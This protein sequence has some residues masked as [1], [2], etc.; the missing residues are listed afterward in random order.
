I[1]KK[2]EIH[3]VGKSLTAKA[4][5]SAGI[6][7]GVDI[8]TKNILLASAAMTMAILLIMIFYDIRISRKLG[9]KRGRL[10]LNACLTIFKSGCLVFIINILTQYLINAPKYAIDELA[11]PDQQTLF[12]ILAMPATFMV[13][14]SNFMV[15]PVI[16]QIKSLIEKRNR[17]GLNRLVGKLNLVVMVIGILGSIAGYFLAAPIFKLI[18][19]VDVSGYE[20]S[21]VLILIGSSF[22]GIVFVLENVLIAFRDMVGQA[23][24]FAIAAASAFLLTRAL[25]IGEAVFG[26]TKAYLIVMSLL[27]VL[28]GVLYYRALE[29]R[30]SGGK[31]K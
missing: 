6:F 29:K 4:V 7:I 22:Y 24:A 14:V 16:N 10:N 21:L 8:A 3:C 27:L 1:Q 31:K 30:I 23:V 18:Y 19:G 28:Y 13:L 25:V 9:F 26:G 11:S 20:W 15:H 17:I 5:L 2:D 12:G